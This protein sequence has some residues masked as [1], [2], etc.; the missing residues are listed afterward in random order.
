VRT[1][2]LFSIL[3]I[4]R[5]RRGPVSAATLAD[6]LNV[7]ERTVY[8]DMATLKAMGAPVRGEGGVGYVIER[9]Y[10]LPPMQFDPDELDVMLLGIRM[11]K[12]RGDAA[13]RDAAER[14]LG[15]IGAV[16]SDSGR[17]LDRPLLAIGRA[18]SAEG[19]EALTPL[20]AAIRDRRK[21]TLQYRDTNGRISD[22]QVR[23]LGLTAFES[24]W[25]LTAWCEMRSDFRNFRLDRIAAF[26]V[27]PERFAREKGKEFQDYLKTL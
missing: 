4:L 8:R 6:L 20:R 7:T 13:M 1:I 12:A 27:T 18:A 22:R 9:G 14:V 25:V 10:F 19:H 24:V 2:R 5:S 23:P 17:P 21:T 15:K 11:V 3:D 26:D 16:L